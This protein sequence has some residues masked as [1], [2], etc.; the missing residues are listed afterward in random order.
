MTKPF[1]I[2]ASKTPWRQNSLVS[3][4]WVM[5]WIRERKTVPGGAVLQ[6]L[7]D[8]ERGQLRPMVFEA[9]ACQGLEALISDASQ[10]LPLRSLRQAFPTDEG[11]GRGTLLP[12]QPVPEGSTLC[13][14]CI[15]A[16]SSWDKRRKRLMAPVGLGKRLNKDWSSWLTRSWKIAQRSCS[17][18]E[19]PNISSTW[20][21]RISASGQCLTG[22][23]LSYCQGFWNDIRTPP[24][25]PPAFQLH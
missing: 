17:A 20:C 25:H 23:I 7:W 3:V 24:L 2:D 21:S 15:F 16:V 13:C 19:L 12:E 8:V 10:N 4:S 1:D 18:H 6:L 22:I 11:Q 14:S 5:I 9:C